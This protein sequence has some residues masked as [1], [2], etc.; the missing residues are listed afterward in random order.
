M[1]QTQL[2]K[3]FSILQEV[4]PSFTPSGKRENTLLELDTLLAEAMSEQQKVLGDFYS[5]RVDQ[6]LDEI[7]SY[8]GKIPRLWK[9]YSS[10]LIIKSEKECIAIDV[11]DGCLPSQGRA[12]IALKETQKKKIAELAQSYFVTHAH[13]D[14]LS[15][16]LSDLFAK[17]K[18]LL[19]MPEDT[20]KR[21]MIKGAVPAEEYKSDS[22]GVFMNWQGDIHGGLPCA[23]YLFTLQN[24]KNV[25]VRGD[26]YHD[27]GF[28]KCVNQVKKWNKKI[29]YAFLTPYYK[30]SVKPVET[31][32]DQ[33]QCRMIP[34]HEWEFAHRPWGIAGK[35]TQNF[36]ELFEA[37][38]LPYQNHS[39]QFLAWGESILLD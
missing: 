25:F 30:G 28:L 34:I 3:I 15:T 35:A 39:A 24:N 29:H 5:R 11:N 9:L 8:N 38:S 22:V 1:K 12:S 17:K 36:E 2:K 16:S 21:W 20:I 37:F 19:V 26:I 4:S 31:L 7:E 18:K 33:F 6:A 27:D 13:N 23:M 14:H 32:Y 10:G